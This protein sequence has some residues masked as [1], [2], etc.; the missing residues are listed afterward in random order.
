M[1]RTPTTAVPLGFQAPAFEL[2]N[3][4]NGLTQTSEGL[5]SGGPTVIVF[6]CNHCP[7]VV[8]ILEEFVRFAH[9][10][11]DKG[12]NVIAISSNEV[13]GYPMDGPEHMAALA[14]E[15]GFRFP[16]LYDESQDIAKAYEAACTP[17]F[18]VFD[19]NQRCVYRGQFDGA[20]P[21]NDIPVT[22]ADM[23]RVLDLLLAGQAI[24]EEGQIPS[25]GCN[26]KWKPE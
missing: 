10:A 15:H 5:M 23:R 2:P 17:D 11:I 6:M 8:H 16:Y 25:L 7:F 3:P 4:V 1:A 9:E 13:T 24:P 12:V 19:A 14:K 18:S 21:G 20:R 26:I 22:G